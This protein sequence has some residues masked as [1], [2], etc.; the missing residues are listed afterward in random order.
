MNAIELLVV[1][2]IVLNILGFIIMGVD[3]RKAIRHAFRIPEATLFII[4]LIG[5]SL[6]SILG[7]YFF[8]HKTRKWYFAYGMPLILVLQLILLYLL[9]H[10]SI[11][12]GVI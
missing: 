4:A 9:F 1:Y 2:F 3:K 11:E 12:I 8:H 5:G 10:S 7:M 6:G